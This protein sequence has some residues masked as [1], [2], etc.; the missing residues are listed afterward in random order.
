MLSSVRLP[1]SVKKSGEA[2]GRRRLLS[3]HQIEVGGGLGA[4][5]GDIWR[6][7]L[8][9]ENARRENVSRL[10]DALKKELS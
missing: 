6:I 4:L 8:M 10:L 2:A 3:E 1:E 9:G 7:G 5:A